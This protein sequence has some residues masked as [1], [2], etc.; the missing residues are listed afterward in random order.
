ME[1]ETVIN[2]NLMK[3]NGTLINFKPMKIPFVI[4]VKTFK[5]HECSYMSSNCIELFWLLCFRM[6]L[7]ILLFLEF[8]H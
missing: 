4:K 8:Q 7:R 6:A 5:S 3:T 1:F 2:Y